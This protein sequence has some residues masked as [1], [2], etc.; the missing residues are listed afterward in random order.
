MHDFLVGLIFL[1]MVL[2]PCVAALTV[3]LKQE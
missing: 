1:A 3:K 2:A